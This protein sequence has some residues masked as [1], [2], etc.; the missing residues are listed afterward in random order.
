MFRTIFTAATILLLSACNLTKEVEIDLPDYAAQPVV[1]CYI[2]PGKPPMMLLSK[3]ANFFADFDTSLNQFIQNI[4]LQGAIA[5]IEHSGT[6][7][8]L[9]NVPFFDMQNQRFFN[10]TGSQVVPYA[11]GDV[12]NLNITLPDGKTITA[13]TIMA[14]YAPIDSLVVEWNPENDTLSRLL[15]YFTDD[16]TTSD[17]YRRMLNRASLDS[18]DQDFTVTDRFSETPKIVFGTGFEYEQGDTLI[19]A[20]FHI[21]EQYYDYLESVQ[22]AFRANVNPFAQPSTIKSNVSG[23]ANAMGI[24]TALIYDRDTIIMQK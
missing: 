10:Y 23:N 21:S 8:T 6:Y 12:F 24:F 20:L 9:K 2:E 13:S 19:S 18:I 5:V 15:T 3:S 1:E 16:V 11:P 7:D 14:K 4:V 22:N 17:Y